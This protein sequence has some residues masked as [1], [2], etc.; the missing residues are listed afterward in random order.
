LDIF[1]GF[2]QTSA[3]KPFAQEKNL[4]NLIV[5]DFDPKKDKNGN[6]FEIRKSDVMRTDNYFQTNEN[7]E[8]E[9]GEKESY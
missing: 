4:S 9:N 8:T 7:L 6:S 1:E 2:N 5:D 3:E